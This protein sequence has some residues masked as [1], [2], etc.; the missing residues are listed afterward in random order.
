[1]RLREVA[2]LLLFFVVLLGEVVQV[3]RIVPSGPDNGL[4]SIL[5][6]SM[7][8]VASFE[9]HARSCGDGTITGEVW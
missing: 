4:A 6:V 1:M 8:E 2:V 7:H 9:P 5:S 3:G